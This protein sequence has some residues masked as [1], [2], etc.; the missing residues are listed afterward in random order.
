M[1]CQFAVIC[2]DYNSGE[3]SYCSRHHDAERCAKASA[4]RNLIVNIIA[5]NVKVR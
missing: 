1:V 3:N 2:N 5:E 4:I